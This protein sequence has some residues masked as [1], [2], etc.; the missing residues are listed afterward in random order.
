VKTALLAAA[1]DVVDAVVDSVVV[2]AAVEDADAV[3]AEVPTEIIHRQAKV[4][5]ERKKMKKKAPATVQRKKSKPL[6]Q[7][8]PE[9]E[10]KLKSK[11]FEDFKRC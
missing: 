3:D 11:E 9:K 7:T 8:V 5:K 4:P 10:L 6:L 1:E 2:V